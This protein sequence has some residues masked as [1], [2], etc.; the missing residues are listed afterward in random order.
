M[1]RAAD[2]PADFCAHGDVEF[3][4]GGDRR[5]LAIDAE[6]QVKADGEFALQSTADIALTAPILSGAAGAE[7]TLAAAGKQPRPSR[8]LRP[9]RFA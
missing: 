3:S 8:R 2:D 5:T 9:N 4:I 1:R 7:L 6:R